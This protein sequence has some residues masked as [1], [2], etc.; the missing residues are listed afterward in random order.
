MSLPHQLGG[1]PKDAAS[2]VRSVRQ[3]KVDYGRIFA[4]FGGILCV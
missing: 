4:C 1:Y 2:K 3:L